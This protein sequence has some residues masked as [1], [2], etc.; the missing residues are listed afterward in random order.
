MTSKIEQLEK[1]IIKLQHHLN[2]ILIPSGRKV[3]LVNPKPHPEQ[4]T[5]N[6]GINKTEVLK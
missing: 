1:H 5:L 4:R 3:D 2:L 6:V